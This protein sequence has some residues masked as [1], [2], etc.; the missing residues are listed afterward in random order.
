[1]KQ[2]LNYFAYGSNLH[3]LRLQ[4]RIGACQIQSVAQLEG[5]QLSFHKVGLDDS[6]KC[7][8]VLPAQSDSTVWG[9]VYQITAEQKMLL[10]HCE[11]LGKGYQI[12]NTEVRSAD[13]QLLSVYTYQAMAEFIDPRLEPF[14]WYHE[15]VFH[16]VCYHGFPVEYQEMIHAVKMIK[17]PN[18]ERTAHQQALL[19]ELRKSIEEQQED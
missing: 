14:D 19:R 17:D 16:G 4:S 6:G 18:R 7:D 3:P 12:L 15:F 5:A 8:I 9:V 10:D 2:T 13:N 1:M 11:S